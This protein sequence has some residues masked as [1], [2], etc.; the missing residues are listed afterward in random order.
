MSGTIT[1][2]KC[3]KLIS[4]LTACFLVLT[5]CIAGMMIHDARSQGPFWLVFGGNTDK[6][7]GQG[8]GMARDQ[9]IAGGWTSAGNSFQVTWNADIGSGTAAQTDAAM[10]PGED[11]IARFCDNGCIIAGF[12]LGTSPALQLAA[13]AGIDAEHTYLF[14]APQP[15]TGIWHA[16]YVDNPFVEPWIASFAG[17]KPDRPVPTGTQVFMDIRDPYANIAPQCQ[18]PGLF[19]LTLEGHRIISKGEA[20]ASHVW[21]GAD[22]AVMHEVGYTGPLG[23]PAS[24]SD[25]P[26]PWAFC[27]PV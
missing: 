16:R 20:D 8:G 22:G 26:Q 7:D 10:G 5:G 2:V 1:W 18:G 23:L 13:E 17:V 27:S 24:G 6:G 15:S 19:A 21:T 3:H 9:L 11:A 14:G 12:S 4:V 25:A